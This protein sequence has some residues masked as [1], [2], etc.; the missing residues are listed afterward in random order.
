MK[1]GSTLFLKLVLLLMGVA[2]LSLCI[3]WIP[4][5]ASRNALAER[6]LAYLKYPFLA[7]VYLMAVPFFIALFQAFKLLNYI[8][9]NKAFSELSIKALKNIKLC[10][11]VI[12]ILIALGILFIVFFIKGDRA[13]IVALGLYTGFATSV[14]ATFAAVLQKLIQSGLEIKTENDLTV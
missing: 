11:I 3:F 13:G 10:A 5:M 9:E 1:Q 7:V 14:V 2:A 4:A 8:D 12:G 6:E